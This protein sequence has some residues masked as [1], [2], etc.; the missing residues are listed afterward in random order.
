V[1]LRAGLVML[2]KGRTGQ[3]SAYGLIQIMNAND[4][5]A[6][7]GRPGPFARHGRIE[8]ENS[9]TSLAIDQ[10]ACS[11]FRSRDSMCHV[12]SRDAPRQQPRPTGLRVGC[13]LVFTGSVIPGSKGK[14]AAGV[15]INRTVTWRRRQ[16]SSSSSLTES[17]GASGWRGSSGLKKRSPRPSGA[18]WPPRE[19][20]LRRAA[21]SR[22][23]ASSPR[24]Q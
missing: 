21:F 20:R 19:R 11:L 1:D 12:K 18:C 3:S 16:S 9:G 14:G 13:T 15:D 17:S 8:G 23:A 22:S 7:Y 5:A 6:R 4:R 2:G 10:R 24:T